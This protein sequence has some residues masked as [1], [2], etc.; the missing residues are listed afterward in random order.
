MNLEILSAA[1]VNAVR[2]SMQDSA[3]NQATVVAGMIREEF[4]DRWLIWSNEHKQWWRSNSH[5][6]CSFK[7]DAGRYTYKEACEIVAGANGGLT[8]HPFE[9]MVLDTPSNPVVKE[10]SQ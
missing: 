1:I 6:Y 3:H 5:G 10:G 8:S 9:T 4:P 2:N 7:K